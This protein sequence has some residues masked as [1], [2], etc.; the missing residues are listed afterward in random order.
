MYLEN[1]ISMPWYTQE[2]R[3]NIL[4]AVRSGGEVAVFAAQVAGLARLW[5]AGVADGHLAARIRVQVGASSQAAAVG[6]YRRSVQVVH[7]G[8]ARGRQAGELHVEF[9]ADATGTGDSRDGAAW[10][11]RLSWNGGDVAGSSCVGDLGSGNDSRR[12]GADD[13]RRGEDGDD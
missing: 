8:A 12:L 6:G 9:D 11:A 1:L 7:E 10:G 3:I 5:L 4:D 13:G 2:V